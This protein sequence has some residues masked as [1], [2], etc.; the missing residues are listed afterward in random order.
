MGNGAYGSPMIMAD[1]TPIDVSIRGFDKL[2]DLLNTE[3]GDLE[4]V[5]DE[6]CN[7]WM[8]TAGDSFYN[9]SYT[10][11]KK[12]ANLITRYKNMSSALDETRVGF[13]ETDTAVSGNI[14]IKP[15]ASIPAGASDR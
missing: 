13:G 11:E 10:A 2:S 7:L 12:M 14:I 5:D 4:T 3:K 6:L 9:A 15:N 1:G 8:G